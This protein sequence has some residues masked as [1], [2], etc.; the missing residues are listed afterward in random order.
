MGF[1]HQRK[2]YR[3]IF[4]GELTGLEVVA[5]SASATAYKRIAGFASREWANPLSAD[6][7]AEFEALCEA[8]ADVLVEW[9]LEE[10]RPGKGKP[11]RKPVPTTLRGLMDQDVGLVMAIVIAWMDAIVMPP[12]PVLDEESLPMDIPTS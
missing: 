11:V 12:E 4:E 9:N 6:D 5:M 10:E 7:L 1:V 3:L 8:F 2:T